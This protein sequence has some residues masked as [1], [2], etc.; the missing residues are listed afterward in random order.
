M[1]DTR[2]NFLKDKN[3]VLIEIQENK[4]TELK[5]IGQSACENKI[6]KEL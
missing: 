3:E 2:M 4:T 6:N 5:W 1:S